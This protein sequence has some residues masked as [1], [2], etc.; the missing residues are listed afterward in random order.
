MGRPASQPMPI[1]GFPSLITNPEAKDA[2]EGA[3]EYAKN[4]L[5]IDPSRGRSRRGLQLFNN[6]DF[7]SPTGVSIRAESPPT[8]AIGA[9]IPV[10][11]NSAGDLI[12]LFQYI[13]RSALRFSGNT[14]VDPDD[15]AYLEMQSSVAGEQPGMVVVD[16]DA[17]TATAET[18]SSSALMGGHTIQVAKGT[19]NKAYF[20]CHSSAGLCYFGTYASAGGFLE[21]RFD[22]TAADPSG[23]AGSALNILTAFGLDANNNIV[24]VGKIA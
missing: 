21:S 17:L 6:V 11:A 24:L 1:R 23:V 8:G 3:T 9:L 14:S 5:P 15:F 12:G 18:L 10:P 4:V 7:D 13:P 19:D 22:P 16:L 20:M 2:G